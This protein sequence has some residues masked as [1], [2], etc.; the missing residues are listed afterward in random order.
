MINYTIAA[1]TAELEGIL[2]LQRSNL[3]PQ[4]TREEISSQG[5]VTVH[6]SFSDLK[7]L[8]DIEPHVI[9]KERDHVI[10][11]LLAMTK[12]SAN[13]IPVLVPM[14]EQFNN[15]SFA[16]KLVSTYNYIVVGQVCVD[17]NYRGMH[18]ID[19]CYAF[20]RTHFENKY[21][22]AITEIAT[23]NVRSLKAHLRVGF[24]ELHRFNDGVEW[25]IV[26]W[27]WNNLRQL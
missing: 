19:D 1:T 23:S 18:I 24:F 26:L 25:S 8:N 4:L 15:L 12:A 16:G 5:F 20:Y 21:D 22:F 7:K 3:A 9:G 13:D 17:K 27:D 2:T 14:F 6:H 11:Y 10:A